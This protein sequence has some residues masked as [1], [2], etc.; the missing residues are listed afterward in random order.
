M[1]VG[2]RK[3]RENGGAVVRGHQW[4][5]RRCS[6][7]SE[8]VRPP[9]PLALMA[10]LRLAIQTHVG[11]CRLRTPGSV[12]PRP[13]PPLPQRSGLRPV[14]CCAE[15]GVLSPPA[16]TSGHTPVPCAQCPCRPPLCPAGDPGEGPCGP[17]SSHAKLWLPHDGPLMLVSSFIQLSL[18][19]C[20]S[21]RPP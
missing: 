12:C 16:P 21:L 15:P 13:A 7:C 20:F 8:R 1:P 4:P 9:L 18:N 14:R 17:G 10:I 2:S 19:A 5:L 3:K 6:P 11:P